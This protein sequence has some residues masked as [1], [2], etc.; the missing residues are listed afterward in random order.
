MEQHVGLGPNAH[1]VKIE[2][3]WPVSK[4]HQTFANVQ[5]NQAIEIQEL[6]HD[7]KKL[8]RKRIRLGATNVHATAH[9]KA[10]GATLWR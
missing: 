5:K 9:N 6:A 3:D 1:N 10:G 2:I 7:Y 4:T 8:V